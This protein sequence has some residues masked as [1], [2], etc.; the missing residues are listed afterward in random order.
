MGVDCTTYVLLGYKL[1]YNSTLGKALVDAFHKY[2]DE[3]DDK[4]HMDDVTVIVDGMNGKYVYIGKVIDS[5]EPHYGDMNV[6]I[7]MI[8]ASAEIHNI[9]ETI[10][11]WFTFGS[12]IPETVPFELH[13]FFHYS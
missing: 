9:V 10:E 12:D 7:D 5:C 3:N 2:R 4:D 1:D 6:S 13:V 11:N 8:D